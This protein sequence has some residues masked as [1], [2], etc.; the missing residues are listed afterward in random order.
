[1][2]R[3][4]INRS[5]AVAR[6]GVSGGEG[7]CGR[8]ESLRSNHRQR[9][10]HFAPHWQCA[11]SQLH[12]GSEAECRSID[13]RRGLHRMRSMRRRL[14]ERSLGAVY[15]IQDQPPGV[16]ASG[17]T[18]TICASI[19]HGSAGQGGAFRKLHQYWRVRGGVPKVHQAGG[20]R[21]DESRLS[22]REL[23]CA[24]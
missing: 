18:R 21:A 10:L 11:R 13:G 14:P 5:R 4:M 24:W 15:R 7:S 20:Y 8:S 9:R 16:T 22:P 19:E 6:T 2:T 23:D 17:T 12:S 3:F 1:M